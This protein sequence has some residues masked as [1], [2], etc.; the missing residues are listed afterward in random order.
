LVPK[1]LAVQ[2][3]KIESAQDQALWAPADCRLERV[4]IRD[5][6]LVLLTVDDRRSAVKFRG[7]RYAVVT[8]GPIEAVARIGACFAG[9]R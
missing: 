3:K 5:A 8:V 9:A 7:G 6:I 1:V 2:M 4:E